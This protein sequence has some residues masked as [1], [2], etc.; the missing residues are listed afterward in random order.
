MAYAEGTTVSVET[1]R[2]EIEK[3]LRKYGAE[4]F[5][6]GYDTGSAFVLFRADSR[7][8]RFVIPAVDAASFSRTGTGR[9]RDVD[10]T[11]KAVEAEE[12]RRWRALLLAIKAKLEV[13]ETGISTFEE[14]FL[15]HVVLPDGQTVADWM[16]PQIAH[17]YETAEMP[18]SLLALGR[19]GR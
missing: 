3:T 16:E 11:A 17:A 2:A 1:S 19:G 9:T 18:T 10:A 8:V 4:S 15:A 14:E 12:R 5:V 7:M 6:S 13:V